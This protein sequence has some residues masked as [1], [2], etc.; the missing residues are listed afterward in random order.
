MAQP[1]DEIHSRKPRRCYLITYSQ[2]DL[3]KFPTKQSFAD[4]VVEAFTSERSQSSPQHWA[5]CIEKHQQQG[6]HYHLAIKLSAP[7]RWLGCKKALERKHG[8]QVHF[9]DHEG[10]YS[11]YKYICKFD[12]DVFHSANHPNLQEIGSPRT[13]VCQQAYRRKRSRPLGN[14]STSQANK[15]SE[16]DR[17]VAK[18]KKLSNIEVSEFIT[19]HEIKDQTSLLATANEQYEQGKRDLAQFVLSRSSKSLDELVQ[20]TWKM[21]EASRIIQR[22]NKSRMEIIREASVENCAQECEGQW[23]ACAKEVLIN[24]KIHPVMYAT[25][26][27]QLLE[28]GRG[29]FRNLL[30]VGPT[31]C[32]K[33]FLLRPLE[34]LFNTF[35]NPASDKYAWVGADNAE[36]IWLN[37]FRWSRELIEWKSFLLLLEGDRVNLPAPKNHF[38]KDVCIDSDVPVFATLKETIKYRGPYNAE[39][40]V[41]NDMMASRW[42]VF[43]FTHSIPEDEQK[44]IPPCGRCFG[45]IVLLGELI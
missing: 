33:T 38:A 16:N 26:I 29:K 7:K 32:G 10:Y 4:A 5:C 45:S 22:K 11:A 9:S 25:A 36:V 30:L 42:K 2:A 15:Q 34:L 12:Q 31:N 27:K 39:D 43:N 21:K 41:E 19:K 18:I 17:S 3:Q 23:L 6:F 35:S 14:C 13:S 37:D 28:C 20:Q 24:N 44:N 8:I 1:I 40:S